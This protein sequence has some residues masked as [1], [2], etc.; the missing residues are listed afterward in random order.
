[1]TLRHTYAYFTQLSVIQN[2]MRQAPVVL[3]GN[4]F[5]DIDN[6]YKIVQIRLTLLHGGSVAEW[7]AC[8]TPVQK[9]PGSNRSRDTF[10]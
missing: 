6:I 10:W 4:N 5:S 9:G 1:M 2:C 8:W 3:F 7:L